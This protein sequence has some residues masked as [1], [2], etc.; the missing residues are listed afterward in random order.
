MQASGGSS[1]QSY[2]TVAMQSIFT[3]IE[4]LNMLVE[5]DWATAFLLKNMIMIV[6]VGESI[7]GGPLEGSRRNWAKSKDVD[8]LKSQ[9]EKTGKAQILYGNHTIT[10]EFAHPEPSVFSPEK[11]DAVINRICTF[12][13]I[14]HYMILGASGGSSRG[15]SYA[16]AA[17]NVQA[18]RTKAAEI[19]GIVDEQFKKVYADDTIVS[20]AF[21]NTGDVTWHD[22]FS[23]VDGNMLKFVDTDFNRLAEDTIGVVEH[24]RN[25]FSTS[26]PLAVKEVNVDNSSLIISGRM[27]ANPE[28]GQFRLL[29]TGKQ[30]IELLGP[31]TTTFDQ[32]GLKE[33]RQVLAE[34]I[35][36]KSDGVISALTYAQELG[37][38]FD[39][40][41]AQKLKELE[42]PELLVPIFEKNQGM[43]EKI[44][45]AT[46]DIAI[47]EIEN[48]NGTPGE[49][50]RPTTRPSGQQ[51]TNENPR[52]STA[53]IDPEDA[54]LAELKI[55]VWKSLKNVPMRLKSMHGVR[56]TLGQINAM[57]KHAEGAEAGGADN[58]WAVARA[59]FQKTHHIKDGK[60]VKN[61]N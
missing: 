24:S 23:S 41:M 43:V 11:Y 22:C 16:A 52:P 14:G 44:L 49:S 17:W 27:P 58:G 36:A 21:M 46:L 29:M 56:L 12:F 6:K 37:W 53:S 25:G 60:W 51:D 55:A 20:A 4:L 34:V 31:P 40:E 7:T 30:S 57:A 19:R 45:A 13:G 15:A 10:I 32:R 5:G 42:I 39:E 54:D 48:G 26:R 3:D 33:D 28:P 47:E 61:K 59:H 18:I 50:G 8:N 38:R 9:I 1:R 2:E 35:A